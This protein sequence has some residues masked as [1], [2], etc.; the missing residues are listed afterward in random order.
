MENL[1]EEPLMVSNDL[2]KCKAGRPRKYSSEEE[3]LE[4]KHK[5][6]REYYTKK[7]EGKEKGQRGKKA[8]RSLEEIR[9]KQREYQKKHREKKKME[10][11]K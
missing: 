11:N 1:I 4:A 5:Q 7:T 9:E 8:F 10:V 6:D 2:K 3:A